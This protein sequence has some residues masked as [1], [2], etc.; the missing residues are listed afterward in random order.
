MPALLERCAAPKVAR[1]G[2][3]LALPGGREVLI[4]AVRPDDA[5][6]ERAF[7]AA[8][9]PAARHLRC[10]MGISA[11]SD[12]MARAFVTVD[13]RSHVALVA[14]SA[15]SV[16]PVLVADARY[17]LTESPGEADFAVVVADAWQGRGLGR[18]LM[19]RLAQRARPG[20]A[21]PAWRRA[22]P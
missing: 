1:Q 4:R 6:R 13:S 7:F 14:E 9:S 15:G 10:H 19:L 17:A 18:A 8:L 12:T 11:L 21:Q 16:A 2:E 5:E 3:R 22:A 20:P